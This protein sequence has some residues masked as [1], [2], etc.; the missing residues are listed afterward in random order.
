MTQPMHILLVDDQPKG[1]ESLDYR[2]KSAGY[3]TTLAEN[4]ELGVQAARADP[5]DLVILDVSMPELNGF[6]ACR[7]LKTLRPELPVVMFTGKADPADKFWATE[8]GADAFIVKPADPAT[9][10]QTL[11][12]LLER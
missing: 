6:Q 3:R 7:A 5:P 4:G 10:M 12:Q 1:L 2:L 11:T 9:V 8:C